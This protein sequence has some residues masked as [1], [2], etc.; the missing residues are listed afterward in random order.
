V[1]YNIFIKFS[2]YLSQCDVLNRVY[3]PE[4]IE[5]LTK[6]TTFSNIRTSKGMSFETFENTITYG[7]KEMR[8]D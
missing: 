3:N 7:L 8:V 2:L 4:D 5:L 6:Q 1:I